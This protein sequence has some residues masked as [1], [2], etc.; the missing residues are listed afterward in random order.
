MFAWV[1]E[2]G[3]D[4]RPVVVVAN[5]TPEI[6]RDYRLGLPRG[7]RWREILNTDAT[8]YGGTGAGNAGMVTAKASAP[9]YGQAW[10][11]LL[12]LPPLSVLWLTPDSE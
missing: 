5:F 2:A 1:R 9:A 12:T 8:V 4:W 11:A 3:P 10:S 6:R 7:G